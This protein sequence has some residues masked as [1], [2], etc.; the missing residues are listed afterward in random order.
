MPWF[1][2]LSM[3]LRRDSVSIT[4]LRCEATSKFW[5]ID[6]SGVGGGAWAAAKPGEG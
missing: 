2:R 4:L 6:G 3:L 1:M 5:L